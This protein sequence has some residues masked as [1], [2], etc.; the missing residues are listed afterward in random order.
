MSLY[1]SLARPQYNPQSNYEPITVDH[2]KW[3]NY[4]LDQA[5]VYDMFDDDQKK[6]YLKEVKEQITGAKYDLQG[7][8]HID[9]SDLGTSPSV[10][11]PEGSQDI[12]LSQPSNI[13]PD[14][15]GINIT[16]GYPDVYDANNIA[17]VNARWFWN[18]RRFTYD[19]A[20]KYYEKYLMYW[21]RFLDDSSQIEQDEAF[22]KGQLPDTVKS[23][24][25][26]RIDFTREEARKQIDVSQP[27]D[28]KLRDQPW[29]PRVNPYYN[30]NLS[31]VEKR[32]MYNTHR[33]TK[34]QADKYEKDEAGGDDGC[35]V[36]P[37]NPK[38]G[39]PDVLRYYEDKLRCGTNTV[40]DDITMDYHHIVDGIHQATNIAPDLI[41]YGGIAALAY[42]AYTL[43]TSPRSVASA[44][45]N[46]GGTVARKATNVAVSSIP[47]VSQV[48]AVL[49]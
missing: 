2:N 5:F 8:N 20:E 34:E 33:F 7:L 17:A 29:S 22:F 39:Y 41:Y 14:R 27:L 9:S 4:Q 24:Y 48:S 35:V 38:L 12:L 18:T 49:S 3:K 47:V 44:V 30:N 15:V 42:G 32:W 19:Q 6:I 11:L 16:I 21:S 13:L 40:A 1:N 23:I 45:Y 26:S 37:P 36:R 10:W 31:T 43:W 46:V 28:T 25:Q